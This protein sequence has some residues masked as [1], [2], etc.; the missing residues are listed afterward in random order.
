MA[1]RDILTEGNPMLRRVS[2]PVTAFD[3]RLWELVKDMK[4]T[5]RHAEGAGLAA[6]Q[7]GIL[8]RVVVIDIGEGAFEL[9]N[10]V[11]TEKSGEQECV[12][13]CLSVPG[14][15]GKTRRPARVTVEAFDHRG[16]P[17]RIEG[18]GLLA[19]A[20]CHELD[21]L[22]GKLYIDIAEGSLWEVDE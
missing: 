2:R 13:G 16:N 6:P 8:R 20:L 11:M 4:Q 17:V 18:E 10:P 15:R 9:I 14:K 22:D 21:H 7:V 3:S 1:L 12:E 19:L 5:L